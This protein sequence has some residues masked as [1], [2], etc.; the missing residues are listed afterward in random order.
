MSES[1]VYSILVNIGSQIGIL[2]KNVRAR[3]GVVAK[4]L[5]LGLAFLIGVVAQ[6]V[7]LAAGNIGFSVV[8]GRNVS[9]QRGVDTFLLSLMANKVMAVIGTRLQAAIKSIGIAR[10]HLYFVSFVEA[11]LVAAYRNVA[12]S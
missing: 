3:N 7:R 6:V 2:E 5:S 4:I 12:V 8:R 10:E 11:A 9:E 1:Q